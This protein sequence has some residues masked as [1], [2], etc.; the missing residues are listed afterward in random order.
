MT[1]FKPDR[2]YD[3]VRLIDGGSYSE[4]ASAKDI[5]TADDGVEVVTMDEELV[6]IPKHNVKEVIVKPESR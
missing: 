2:E 5:R 3:K 4:G 1:V 6:F